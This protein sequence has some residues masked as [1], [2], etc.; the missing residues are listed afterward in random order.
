MNDPA[1]DLR[2]CGFCGTGQ[3]VRAFAAAEYKTLAGRAVWQMRRIAAV[4]AYCDGLHY[5]TQWDEYCR[6][7]Q[8]RP[9][10]ISAFAWQVTVSTFTGWPIE[11]VPDHVAPLMTLAV[12]WNELDDEGQEGLTEVFIDLGLI[13]R[14]LSKL[15]ED[16]ARRQDLSRLQRRRDDP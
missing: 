3:A 16:L 1:P 13:E 2:D 5:R 7:V 12:A 14:H 15:V 6:Y 4:G 8:D 9:D 11:N 10:G